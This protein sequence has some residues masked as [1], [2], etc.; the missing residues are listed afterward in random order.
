VKWAD[1]RILRRKKFA[2]L[3]AIKILEEP[4]HDI[5]S[6]FEATL[7]FRN[8]GIDHAQKEELRSK[9]NLQEENGKN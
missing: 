9:A 7:T 2:N 6:K 5:H 4:K 3:N 1:W 8:T